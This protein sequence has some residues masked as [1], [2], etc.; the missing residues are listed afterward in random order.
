MVLDVQS[1]SAELTNE[2]VG[3]PEVVL[4]K[5]VAKESAARRITCYMCMF[6]LSFG[7]IWVVHNLFL[8]LFFLKKIMFLL[9]LLTRTLSMMEKDEVELGG[10]VVTVR[11]KP[12][13]LSMS[14]RYGLVTVTR[15]PTDSVL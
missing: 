10:P 3:Q 8:L 1:C 11:C 14:V 2:L 4:I 7:K 6:L 12:G 5:A 9:F 13:L 15:A